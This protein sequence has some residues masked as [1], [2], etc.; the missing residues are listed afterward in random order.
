MQ[1]FVS[2]TSSMVQTGMGGKLMLKITKKFYDDHVA[3]DLPSPKILKETK[4][5]YYICIKDKSAL[6]E[7]EDDADYY[8][9][10]DG[11]YVERSMVQSARATLKKLQSINI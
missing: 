8:S 4:N 9:N 6:N 1:I 5:H 2:V 10:G 11:L 7:L 3:R